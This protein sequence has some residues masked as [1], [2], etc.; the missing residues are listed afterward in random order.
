MIFFYECI[1]CRKKTHLV[2]Y[3]N[4]YFYIKK[5]FSFFL[6]HILW[7]GL[8]SYN[9]PTLIVTYAGHLFLWIVW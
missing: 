5:N 7:I 8:K 2:G 4:A 3:P 6:I 1:T 9:Q